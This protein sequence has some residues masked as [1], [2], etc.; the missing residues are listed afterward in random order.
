MSNR[1]VGSTGYGEEFAQTIQAHPLRTPGEE[2]N[3]AADAVIRVYP[4][5]DPARQCAGGASYCGHLS[6]WLRA[7]VRAAT[8]AGL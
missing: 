7:E 4:A 3:E 2:L 1:L 5:I 8:A 6:N